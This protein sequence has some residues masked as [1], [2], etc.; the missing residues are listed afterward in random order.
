MWLLDFCTGFIEIFRSRYVRYLETEVTRL[1]QECAGLN[2]TLLS[3]KGIHQV[4]SPDMQDL[5]ARGRALSHPEK[6]MKGNMRPV[7][8][9]MTQN[10]LK[11]QLEAK[12]RQVALQDE[13]EIKQ[14]HEERQKQKEAANAAQ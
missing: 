10:R 12:S 13:A 6:G 5:T 7:V 2:H 14:L 11:Q 4:A 3:T 9:R 8:G 1:R